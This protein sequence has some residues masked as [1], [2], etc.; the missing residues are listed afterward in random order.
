M[1]AAS[2]ASTSAIAWPFSTLA[3]VCLVMT[4]SQAEGDPLAPSQAFTN[5]SRSRF[6]YRNLGGGVVPVLTLG[7][8]ALGAF[9]ATGLG[10]VA[11][12]VVFGLLVSPA[13]C[14]PVEPV[15]WTGGCELVVAGAVAVAGVLVAAFVL[16]VF[17]VS[18]QPLAASARPA[19]SPKID[20]LATVRH[21]K[22]CPKEPAL[23]RSHLQRRR[24]FASVSDAGRRKSVT[25]SRF[26]NC[27]EGLHA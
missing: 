23:S 6:G 15:L 8:T 20:V 11:V 13:G 7:L 19:K 21:S 4:H 26:S 16:V 18:P 3:R 2:S 17:M 27:G 10:W 12:S 5:A 1:S 14:A 25:V 22:P 9:L 24:D